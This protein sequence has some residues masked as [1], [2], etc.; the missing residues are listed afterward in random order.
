MT[1]GKIGVVVLPGALSLA[2]E[3]PRFEVASVKAA[4]PDGRWQ[5]SVA[6]GRFT[7]ANCTLLRLIR[8]AYD[9]QDHQISGGPNWLDS[10][11]F[12]IDTTVDSA[13]VVP[14]GIAAYPVL[15]PMLKS[16]LAERFNI[17]VHTETREE[18][19]YNLILDKGGSRLREVSEPGSMHK[20]KGE[21]IGTGAPMTFLVAQLSE[22][23]G[24]PVIDKTGLTAHYDFSL[25]WSPDPAAETSG[26]SLFT[27]LQSDLG[28]KLQSTKAPVEILVIDHAEKPDAN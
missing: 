7:A 14:P 8:V 23:L 22:Q 13:T 25:K 26:P 15:R 20:A 2:A 10:A 12:N 24:R 1:A 16:L 9:L 21:L 11:K 3:S 27:A 6:H 5:T 19:V 4:D 28:L 18:T 17:T